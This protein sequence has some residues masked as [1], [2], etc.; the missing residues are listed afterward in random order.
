MPINNYI[1]EGKLVV[2]ENATAYS[3]IAAGRMVAIDSGANNI[4]TLDCGTAGFSGTGNMLGARFIGVLDDNVSANQSPIAVW[5]E[6]VFQFYLEAG[7]TTAALIGRPAFAG[8]GGGGA[9]VNT[10][11]IGTNPTG[12]HPIGT[13]VGVS[14]MTTT[15]PAA[16]IGSSGTFCRVKI[17]PGA[18]RWGPRA[19]ATGSC[20]S[21]NFPPLD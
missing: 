20:L 9:N 10:L 12:Q 19:V 8:S 17:T 15:A 2:F 14:T 4:T 16:T 5:T 21:F 1:S 13:F 7:I 18:F 3:N 11:A 6:G